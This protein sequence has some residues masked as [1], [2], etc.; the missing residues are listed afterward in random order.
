MKTKIN[1]EGW[2]SLNTPQQKTAIP[3]GSPQ[4]HH[5]KRQFKQNCYSVDIM[6]IS[7][8]ATEIHF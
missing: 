2:H 1:K 7:N 4:G 8:K 3:A 5:K 6:R